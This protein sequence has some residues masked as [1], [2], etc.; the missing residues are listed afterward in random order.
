[1]TALHPSLASGRWFTFTLSEQ[2]GNIGSEVGR[3]ITWKTKNF[4]EQSLLA[5]T[6]ALELFYLTLADKRWAGAR[7]REIA[8]AKEV[9]CD[10]LV[11]DN[12]FQSDPVGLQKYFDTFAWAARHKT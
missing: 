3:A 4:P 7:R 6:R 12:Q 8:R 10:F 2:L 9:V 1:M 11:G 5:L